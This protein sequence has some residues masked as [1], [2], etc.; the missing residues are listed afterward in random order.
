MSLTATWDT[1]LNRVKLDTTALGA[2][3]VRT[4]ITRYENLALTNGQ[5]IR[6]GDVSPT[7]NANFTAYDS[8]Y[9][10]NTLLTYKVD[11]YNVSNVVVTTFTTT[12][13]VALDRIW[14]KSPARPFLDR[15]VTVTEFGAVSTQARGGTIQVAGRRAPVAITEVRGQ[16]QYE[17]VLRAADAVEA[18]AVE[19]FLAFGDVVYLQVPA[20]C[21]VPS[22]MYAF[23][24]DVSVVQRGAHLTAVRYYHLPLTEV[25]APDPT[26]VGYTVTWLGI[27]TAYATW[28]ALKAAKATWQL[29]QEH[30]SAPVDEIVG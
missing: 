25:A 2:T 19:A 28:T 20:G 3:V 10:P 22:S 15:Q 26:I 4:V 17:L 9:K 24:G 18:A 13:T 30:V 23:V 14:L 7:T 8:E 1:V 29:V 11:G 5:T 16:R 21:A 27:R 12:I 6:G